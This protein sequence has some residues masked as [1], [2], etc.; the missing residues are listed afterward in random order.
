MQ[1]Q[2]KQFRIEFWLENIWFW[3]CWT[4][5]NAYTT[6]F[7]NLAKIYFAQA[8]V[9]NAPPAKS[10]ISKIYIWRRRLLEITRLRNI[11]FRF[12]ICGLGVTNKLP[13]SD[14]TKK[15]YFGIFCKRVPLICPQ[16][17]TFSKNW[18]PEGFKSRFDCLEPRA[19]RELSIDVLYVTRASIC[20]ELRPFYCSKRISVP[21][22]D[23]KFVV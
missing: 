9:E 12:F 21:M 15:H 13:A 11:E 22:S 7:L 19:R 20:V 6:I 2:K 4:L 1:C 3:R 8:P 10:L 18:V 17:P 16:G 14:K 23:I 5:W